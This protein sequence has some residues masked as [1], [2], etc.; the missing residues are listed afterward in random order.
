MVYI[1]VR[2]EPNFYHKRKQKGLYSS[3]LQQKKD[4]NLLSGHLI[5]PQ[6]EQNEQQFC[7]GL[8]TSLLLNEAH[9]LI[10]LKAGFGVG[11][12]LL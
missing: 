12:R 11:R 1:H 3:Y 6:K 8:K 5:R 2:S 7:H 10:W 9:S 4:F